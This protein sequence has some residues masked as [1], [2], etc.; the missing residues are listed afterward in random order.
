MSH[1][2]LSSPSP[3]AA[4]ATPRRKVPL[5]RPLRHPRYRSIWL[6]NLVSNLGTWIQTFASA[7]LVASLSKS[8]AITSLVQTAAYVP[9]FLF[10]LFAGVV[11]DA[12]HRPKFLFFCNLYM[13]CCAGAMALLGELNQ[14]DPSTDKL[15]SLS[16]L[17]YLAGKRAEPM[18]RR[19]ALDT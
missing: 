7:W 15:Y 5:T 1:A 9:I 2:S 6:A 12:V 11:A 17:A 8:A 13:A 10:A 3:A 19:K 14:L 16:E 18:S 4:P